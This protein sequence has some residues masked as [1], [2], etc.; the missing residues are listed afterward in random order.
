[1]EAK[2]VL[3]PGGADQTAETQG[4][5]MGWKGGRTGWESGMTLRPAHS[6]EGLRRVEC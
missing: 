1:M 4:W 6:Q 5:D 3:V 2:G